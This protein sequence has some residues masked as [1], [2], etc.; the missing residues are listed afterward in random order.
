MVSLEKCFGEMYNVCLRNGD[1]GVKGGDQGHKRGAGRARGQ[2]SRYGFFYVRKNGLMGSGDEGRGRG[3]WRK[4]VRLR[5][6]MQVR[7]FQR[8]EEERIDREW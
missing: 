8:R 6:R 3:L 1:E 4:Y 7:L 2:G 5:T